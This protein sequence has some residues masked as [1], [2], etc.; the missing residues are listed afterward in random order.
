MMRLRGGSGPDTTTNLGV[1]AVEGD[2]LVMHQILSALE[3]C[4]VTLGTP[5]QHLAEFVSALP[6][7][8]QP[9][10]LVL[11]PSQADE[12]TLG[13]VGALVHLHPWIGA[14]LVVAQPDTSVLRA[15]L[16]AG[17]SDAVPLERVQEDLPTA[18]DEL[19]RHL[20]VGR[21]AA[22]TAPSAGQAAPAPG[23]VVSVFSA[24]GGVGKSTV[25]VNL[26]T[27]LASR[28]TQRVVLVDADLQFG[29]VGV[30]LRLRP[31]HGLLEAIAAG[32]QLD[33][34]LLERL[35]LRDSRSGLFVLPAPTD[36][37]AGAKI[38]PQQ[39][40]NLVGHLREMGTI[41]VIDMPSLL[42]D[43]VLQLLAESDDIV[44]LVGTDVPAVKN[45]RL[46][47]QA[48]ELVQIPLGRVLVVLNRAD[49]KGGLPSRDIEKILEMQ[50]DFSLPSDD[51]VPKTVNEGNPAVLAHTKSRFSGRVRAM[52]EL[53]LARSTAEV[54]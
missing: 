43:I 13:E 14:L 10:I 7:G 8:D 42:D 24:K 35:L 4:S 41:T 15:A 5:R 51:L 54:R 44:Y 37:T 18:V 40:S 26:A 16:R 2:P 53:L 17:V 39:I 9:T 31:D 30:M 22:T 52:A 34:V 36:P 28:T 12:N 38:T 3:G 29:D 48:V 6:P 11:G 20:E 33:P 47:L 25:A 21:A 27:E 23:R 32:D 1:V 45:A 19:S 46:G 49:V 50:I